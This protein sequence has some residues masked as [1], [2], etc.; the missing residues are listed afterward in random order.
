[1]VNIRTETSEDYNE[2]YELHYQAF[3]N[4]DDES[5]LVKRIRRSGQFIPELSIVAEWNKEIVGHLLLSK[6][7]VS[8][9]GKE[10]P[11]I[12]LST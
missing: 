2:V 9:N 6:A 1:L 8:D 5:C 12:V 10:H 11:V 3:G 4:R 7:H